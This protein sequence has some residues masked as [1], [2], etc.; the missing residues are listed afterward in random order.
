M[1]GTFAKEEEPVKYGVFPRINSINPIAIF[2]NGYIKLVKQIVHAPTWSVR[3]KLLV[4]SPMWAWHQNKQ[5][6]ESLTAAHKM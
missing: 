6:T 3:V 1:F 5:Q 2:F 4:K